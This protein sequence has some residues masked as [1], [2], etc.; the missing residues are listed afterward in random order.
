MGRVLDLNFRTG[1]SLFCALYEF[2]KCAKNRA[3][4]VNASGQVNDDSKTTVE[5]TKHGIKEGLAIFPRHPSFKYQNGQPFGFRLADA[6][7]T[8]ITTN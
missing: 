6:R 1:N 5:R 8:G 7:D 4:H 2:V 3:I